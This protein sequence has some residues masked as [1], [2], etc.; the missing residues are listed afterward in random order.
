MK[1]SH[2]HIEVSGQHMNVLHQHMKVSHLVI[3]TD[4]CTE[5]EVKNVRMA[6]MKH[7]FIN[8]CFIFLQPILLS[9]SKMP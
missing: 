1:V 9:F 8:N 5:H 7:R 4:I 2:Q 6:L 3:V